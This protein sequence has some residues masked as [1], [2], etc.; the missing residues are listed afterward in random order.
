MDTAIEYSLAFI[1]NEESIREF[2]IELSEDF[3]TL[4]EGF[5]QH[6]TFFTTFFQK[7]K[8]QNGNCII[9]AQVH[10][11]ISIRATEKISSIDNSDIDPQESIGDNIK[12]EL[13][14]PHLINEETCY[15]SV[16]GNH[17]ETG[18]ISVDFKSLY[19]EIN[20]ENED[21]DLNVDVFKFELE[22]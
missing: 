10:H 6:P 14:E 9:N 7:C 18:M 21:W 2:F 5:Y 20:T 11:K 13:S 15:R 12:D 3:I 8:E 1:D 22:V 16:K 19:V 17:Y 4:F